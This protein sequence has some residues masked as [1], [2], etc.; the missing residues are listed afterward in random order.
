[1]KLCDVL[2]DLR[3]LDLRAPEELDIIG[4]TYDPRSSPGGNH[5]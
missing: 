4:I 5:K 1:M 2:K 3:L